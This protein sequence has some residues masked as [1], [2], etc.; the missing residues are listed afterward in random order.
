MIGREI[1]LATGLIYAASAAAQT[2]PAPA[3]QAGQNTQDRLA[4]KMIN[5][6]GS[7]WYVYGAGQTNEKLP[8]GG[9]KAYPAVRV[10]VAAKSNNPWDVGAVSPLTKPIAAGDVISVV[11][12][13]RAPMLKD[14]ETTPIPYI[15]LGHAAAPYDQIAKASVNVTNQWKVYFASG[16]AASAF[17]ADAATVGIHLAADKHVIELGPVRVL[18]FGPDMDVSKLPGNDPG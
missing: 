13:L 15:G 1:A 7:D 9:P 6:L 4:D 14:G 18:D 10:T 16:K 2:A 5:A 8:T 12:Y 11:V 3:A 17:A